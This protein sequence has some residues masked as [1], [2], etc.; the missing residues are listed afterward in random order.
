M[1]ENITDN[2]ITR[3]IY[4]MAA[5]EASMISTGANSYCEET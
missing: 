3:V 1:M 5:Y 4:P 2:I